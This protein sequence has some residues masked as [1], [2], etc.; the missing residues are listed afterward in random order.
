MIHWKSPGRWIPMAVATL[1]VLAM[2]A[3]RW[4][5]RT[6][7]TSL[8]SFGGPKFEQ[9]LP[10]LRTL[11]IAQDKDTGYDGQFGAQLAV[12][13]DP[14]SPE[15]RSALDNPAYRARRIFLAWTAHVIG[16]GGPWRVLQVYALQN[17]AIWLGLAWLVWRE[18]RPPSDT[19][20]VAVW[21]SCMLTIG[22]L[23]C[24]RLS[25]TDLFAVFLLA[26]AV[27]ALA[28][29]R[30]WAAAGALA[31]AG[32]TRESSLLGGAVLW[33][34]GEQGRRARLLAAARIACAAFPLLAW[35]AWLACAVSREGTFGRNNFDWPCSAFV[36]HCSLCVDRLAH[37]DFD[38]RHL[39]GLIGAL[40][41]AGQSLH[42]LLRPRWT[43]PW[44]RV[45]AGF[46]LLFWFL[47][48]DVWKGYWA[49]ARALLP[50]TFAFNILAPDDRRFWA[51]L[52]LANAGLVLHGI[53]RML[54]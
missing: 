17:L 11:P 47:G 38:S 45:G 34:A 35:M 26:L 8:L 13:P 46:A 28:R 14:R 39:F 10:A 24:V 41:L 36:R 19:R 42:L 23:D 29:G 30:P 49:A 9:R 18:L 53:W 4:D 21:V 32:L 25:L 40:G 27:R 54:P 48:D 20:A 44:W 5:P 6:G 2:V 50:M 52:T 15:I 33:P 31:V 16:G 3:V 43:E 1:F 7:F 12:S 37:G 22:A 51:R